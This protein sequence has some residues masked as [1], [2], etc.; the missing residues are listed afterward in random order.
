MFLDVVF[1]WH[2]VKNPVAEGGGEEV[3]NHHTLSFS[4]GNDAGTCRASAQGP[5]VER[6]MEKRRKAVMKSVRRL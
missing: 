3:W 5:R 1:L 4:S 6:G 2:P